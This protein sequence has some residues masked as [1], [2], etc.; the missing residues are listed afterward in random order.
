MQHTLYKS[1]KT[2]PGSHRI[3]FLFSAPIFLHFFFSLSFSF[4]KE[5]K[6]HVIPSGHHQRFVESRL[7]TSAQPPQAKHW[8]SE[9]RLKNLTQK[10]KQR[11]CSKDRK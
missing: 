10:K 5:K 9:K 1:G 2:P 7:P 8:E 4:K 11:N 3:Y 6:K